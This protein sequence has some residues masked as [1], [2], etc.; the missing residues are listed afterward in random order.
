MNFDGELNKQW[1]L[2]FLNLFSS[3]VLLNNIV[4]RKVPELNVRLQQ[5][6]C[7][8]ADCVLGRQLEA[9]CLLEAGQGCD[10]SS[11]STCLNPTLRYSVFSMMLTGVT[12]SESEQVPVTPF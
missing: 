11:M 12:F 2:T 7:Q 8:S 9:L 3:S 1:P 6:R 5:G 4:W 10:S